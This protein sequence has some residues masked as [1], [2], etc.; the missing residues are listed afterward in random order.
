MSIVVEALILFAGFVITGIIMTFGFAEWYVKTKVRGGTLLVFID[1][2]KQ[3][4]RKLVIMGSRI[5]ADL[6]LGNTNGTYVID[7]EFKFEE[8][9]P[10]GFPSLFREKVPTYYFMIR[11]YEP[12]AL[13][14]KPPITMEGN[15]EKKKELVHYEVEAENI[16]PMESHKDGYITAELL[17]SL[18]DEAFM[19]AMIKEH[20]EHAEG[21]ERK[22]KVNPVYLLWG[23]IIANLL[24]A[25]NIYLVWV[26]NKASSSP[27]VTETIDKLTTGG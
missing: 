12:L 21:M 5:T 3:I 17:N 20:R 13:D 18:T 8:D 23:V 25:I 24:I 7:P 27:T 14:H 19:A 1:A 9:Y 26:L 2:N 4:T 16:N 15:K 10:P 6:I 22:D 11:N